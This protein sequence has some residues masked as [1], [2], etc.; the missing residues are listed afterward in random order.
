MSSTPPH[1]HHTGPDHT[2]AGPSLLRLLLQ[3]LLQYSLFPVVQPAQ[4]L[5]WL[6]PGPYQVVVLCS[7][8]GRNDCSLCLPVCPDLWVE[9][10]IGVTSRHA[11]TGSA[12]NSPSFP[13]L[14][15][16]RSPM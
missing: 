16:I 15:P 14:L 12:Q 4:E 9:P 10:L 5:M 8:S 6:Q 11:R 13:F 1:L 7:S 2:R 3:F